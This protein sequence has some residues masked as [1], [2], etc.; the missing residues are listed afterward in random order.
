MAEQH[1]R[2]PS[3]NTEQFRAFVQSTEPAQ[4]RSLPIGLIAG[5]GAAVVVLIAVVAWFA[6]S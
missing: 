3:G 5:L 4:E 2:D 1:H 6:L